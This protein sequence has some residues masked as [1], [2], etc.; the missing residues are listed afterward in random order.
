MAVAAF[1]LIGISHQAA[2]I[3][4]IGSN[5]VHF[6]NH[7][8]S[9]SPVSEVSAVI[10]PIRGTD[11]GFIVLDDSDFLGVPDGEDRLEGS[12]AAVSLASARL[13]DGPAA[14]VPGLRA[15]TRIDF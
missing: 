12:R 8:G 7:P 9:F 10:G 4:V 14:A 11:D 3:T 15:E 13:L 1:M 5:P 6:A 2:A